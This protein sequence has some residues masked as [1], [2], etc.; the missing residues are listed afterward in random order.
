MMK[1]AFIFFMFIMLAAGVVSAA[2]VSVETVEVISL[3]GNVKVI[4]AGETREVV[5][6][7]GMLLEKGDRIKTGGGAYVE[8]A[9][10]RRMD[11]VIRIEGSSD[12]ALKLDEENIELVNGEVFAA[13]KNLKKGE[14]FR[15]R[16][17]CVVCGV[18]G[19]GW[20]TVT[21]SKESTVSVL[22]GS[23]FARGI[24][25]DGSIMEKSFI[26]NQGFERKIKKFERPEK[27]AKISERKFE[28]MKES[29]KPYFKA[30]EISERRPR[31]VRIFRPR[32]A[33]GRRLP[34]DERLEKMETIQTKTS[35]TIQKWEKR[36]AGVIQRKDEKRIETIREEREAADVRSTT[37][38]KP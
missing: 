35:R 25:R 27:M 7:A 19:T 24:N 5:C 13:I 36:D 38:T 30:K 31:P 2:S 20:N 1:K 23:V 4:P 28:K 11:N 37:V 3:S 10:D 29:G 12:V 15:V 17:P 6:Q 26:I 18:R 32:E 8:I 22:N 14:P 21:D 9:F 33:A 34:T 16:T